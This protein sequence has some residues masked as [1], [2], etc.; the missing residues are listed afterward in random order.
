MTTGLRQKINVT[1]LTQASDDAIGGAIYTGSCVYDNLPAQVIQR[2][3]SQTAL[4]QGLEVQAVFDCT[5]PA[6]RFNKLITIY[7]R[8]QI[9]IK[10]PSGDPFHDKNFRVTGIRP[11][12]HRRHGGGYIHL[13]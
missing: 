13:T 2:M 7:H 9:T 12:K 4:E 5:V 8:D 3:P 1:R 11:S 10:H 6:K